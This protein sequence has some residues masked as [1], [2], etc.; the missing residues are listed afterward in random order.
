MDAHGEFTYS[1]ILRIFD[2]RS[3]VSVNFES[4]EVLKWL[5]RISFDSTDLDYMVNVLTDIRIA[6]IFDLDKANWLTMD[7]SVTTD[8]NIA[9]S[10]DD[11]TTP[12]TCVKMDV[13]VEEPLS[14]PMNM[15]MSMGVRSI[16]D[17]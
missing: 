2:I 9:G 14:I 15:N 12:M 4:K 6:V 13:L 1:T 17:F 3:A 10:D 16:A 8:G 11:S 7:M 5:G